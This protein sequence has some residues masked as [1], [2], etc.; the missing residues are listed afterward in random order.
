MP[1]TQS[2]IAW[3]ERFFA[4]R[5]GREALFLPSGRLALLLIFNTWLRR[6]DRILMS[7]VNDD[8]VF[9]LVLAAGL[10]PVIGPL[11]PATGN[12]DPDAVPAE[13]WPTL[14]AVLTTNLYGI[15]D[16][17]QRLRNHCD[18]HGSLLIEDACHALD[19]RFCGQRIGSFGPVA[20]FSLAK[21]LN[22]AGGILSFADSSQRSNLI[23]LA[24]KLMQPRRLPVSLSYLVRPY[25]LDIIQRLH[26]AS[27]ALR[28]RNALG[29]GRAGN[30]GD[31]MPYH[32]NDIELARKAADPLTGFRHWLRMD[33]AAWRMP[34]PAFYLRTIVN[35]L[36]GLDENLNRRRTGQ[37][38][39]RE[40]GHIPGTISLPDNTALFRVPLFAK[41]R[42]RIRKRCETRGLPINYIYDPPL[43]NYAHP[44][45]AVRIPSPPAA[46][47]WSRDVLPVDPLHARRF[48]TIMERMRNPVPAWTQS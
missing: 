31:R 46:L 34:A 10:E 21:H 8:V 41:D 28:A 48:V 16:N 9:F 23:A 26:L 25:L 43:D 36:D 35:R 32:I 33:H 5:Y 14:R 13:L 18:R 15:P 42:D 22:V 29:L 38:L 20:V 27:G 24:S 12:L 7:P 47:V 3:I 6:G 11:D 44:S 1:G 2:R 37:R 4:D 17:M 19:S 40:C 30:G 39:I 45:L